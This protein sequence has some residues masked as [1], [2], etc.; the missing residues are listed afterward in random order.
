MSDI[1]TYLNL[2]CWN[3]VFESDVDMLFVIANI[4]MCAKEVGSSNDCSS[5]GQEMME[6]D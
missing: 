5:L 3:D 1:Q 6:G 2:V 4:E